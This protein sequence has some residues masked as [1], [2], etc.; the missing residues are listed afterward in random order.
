M[1]RFVTTLLALLLTVTL[2]VGLTACKD[3]DEE[4][5]N[6]EAITEQQWN[7]FVE[8]SSEYRHCKVPADWN[9]T[10]EQ[11]YTIKMNGFEYKQDSTAKYDMLNKACSWYSTMTGGGQKYITQCYQWEDANGKVWSYIDDAEGI[12]KVLMGNGMSETGLDDVLSEV[13]HAFLM[14]EQETASYQEKPMTFADLKFDEMSKGYKLHRESDSEI[15][16][17]EYYFIDGKI[18]KFKLNRVYRGDGYE[19]SETAVEKYVYGNTTVTIPDEV[20]NY[21]G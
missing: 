16:D 4:N 10:M 20:K 19:T 1:K 8:L 14:T 11:N 21:Q 9:V 7:E 17:I 15:M 5:E 18:A 12:R 13:C 2:A 3:S 6:Y